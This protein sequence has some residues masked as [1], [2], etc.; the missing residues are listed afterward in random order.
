M[1][2]SGLIP[3]S[4]ERKTNKGEVAE[5]SIAA[6]CKPAAHV[7]TEVRTL[8]SPPTFFCVGAL[9]VERAAEEGWWRCWFWRQAALRAAPRVSGAFAGT[10]GK[11]ASRQ[12]LSEESSRACPP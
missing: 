1:K 3:D 2:E 6:G 5:R 7:A 9:K 10:L 11:L 8:P 4:Y 12:G